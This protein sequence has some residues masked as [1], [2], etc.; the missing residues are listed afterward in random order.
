MKTNS[1]SRTITQMVAFIFLVILF[2]C[3][4][5]KKKQNPEIPINETEVVS[6]SYFKLS[7]AEWSLH[8]KFNDEGVS[9]FEFAKIAD[10]LGFNT[11]EYVSQL[12]TKQIAEVGFD[13][14]INRLKYESTKYG[15]KNN[16]IMVDH[17][18]DLADPDLKVRNQAIENHKK[19]VDAAYKL[20]CQ[21]IRV[22]TFGTNNPE[23]WKV[24]VVAGLKEL[25]EYA[26]TRNINVICENHGWLSSDAP[27]LMAALDAVN[28]PNCGTLPD[29]GNWC[30]KRSE[31]YFGGE[32]LELFPDKYEGIKLM[33][34]KAKG[35]SAKS[36]DFDQN[37][38]ETTIDYGRMLQIVKDSGF[39]GIIGIEYEGIRLNEIDGIIATKNLVLNSVASLK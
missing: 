5:N 19:W 12:Y 32:C 18:G 7:L 21:A 35:V 4:N 14:V 15:L 22:N 31:D 16:L 29:F 28:L 36:Y 39:K 11:L 37:G 38:I 3:G 17:E 23:I 34:P 1:L 33:M 9:P 2:G 26:A 10:S 30:I 27:K 8:R 25:S 6:E 24:S 20:G 13:S